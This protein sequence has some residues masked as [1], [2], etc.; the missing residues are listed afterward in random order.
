MAAQVT[1]GIICVVVL[2]GVLFG[3][4]NIPALRLN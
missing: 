4:I 3:S 1:L 2:L